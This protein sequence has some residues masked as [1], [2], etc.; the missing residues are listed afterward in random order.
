MISELRIPA[1]PGATVRIR[2]L[3]VPGGI[4]RS[5]L[6]LAGRAA[7]VVPVRQA[8]T[9]GSVTVAEVGGV[10]VF[11]TAERTGKSRKLATV[12]T[13][14][15]RIDVR[16]AVNV[17]T[18]LITRVA[19]GG[20][21]GT[22]RRVVMTPEVRDVETAAGGDRVMSDANVPPVVNV[23]TTGA[24]GRLVVV[25]P[26]SRDRAV[27]AETVPPGMAIAMSSRCPTLTLNRTGRTG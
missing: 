4:R 14:A 22:P 26:A 12:T 3:S 7:A 16:H 6:N 5:L 24:I 1:V 21:K 17:R 18:T 8:T 27:T 10:K 13:I 23:R 25:I 15:A 11:G 20:T 2:T 19:P 9:K